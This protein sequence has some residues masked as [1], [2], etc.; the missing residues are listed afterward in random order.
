[1]AFKL[2]REGT[3]TS[4]YVLIDEENGYIKF[5][6]KSYL[7]DIFGFFKE[8]NE[9]LDKYL[10]SGSVELTFDCKML[11]F[12]SA[13]TKMI[14]NMLRSMDKAA[15]N[16]ASITV[17]WIAAEDDEM[18]IECGEEFEEDMEHLT[19]NMVTEDD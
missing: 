8:I 9:W 3:K 18:I 15:E 7:E 5:E 16:G 1:M 13:T 4:P 10:S 11:Y 2:E 12:N 6:G 17:N 19:F 14:F